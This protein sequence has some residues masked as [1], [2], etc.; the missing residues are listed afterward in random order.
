MIEYIK[1]P[2]QNIE[3]IWISQQT[4]KILEM[5]WIVLKRCLKKDF[6]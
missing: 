1:Q 6:I 4:F 5:Q 2:L 3:N